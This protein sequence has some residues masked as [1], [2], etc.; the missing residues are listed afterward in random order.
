MPTQI[1]DGLLSYL[2]WIIPITVLA[3]V[4]NGCG[5]VETKPYEE[6]GDRKNRTDN[7]SL[8]TGKDTS[9]ISL[10]DLL[11]PKSSGTGSMP[12]NAI[13]WRAALDTV[14]VVPIDDIDT[15]GGTILT[16]WYP[17][18][19]NANQRIKIAV[20]VIDRELRADAIRVLVYVQQSQGSTWTDMGQDAD[21]ARR[22][23]DLILT[24]A[25]EI[26][27]ANIQDAQ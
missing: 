3:M 24:R 18:P 10:D 25:R 9:G 8:L 4:L 6:P 16:E 7:G 15:F 2:R 13:L 23:E 20:F 27:S 11:N 26:R 19:S 22:M 5:Y 14:S 21:F 12:V 17:H 1:T